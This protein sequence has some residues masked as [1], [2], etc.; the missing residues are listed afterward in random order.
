[1]YKKWIVNDITHV[2]MLINLL[3]GLYISN[4]YIV[5]MFFV[6]FFYKLYRFAKEYEYWQNKSRNIAG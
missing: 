1:M 2:V 6:W 5:T 4:Y 3:F